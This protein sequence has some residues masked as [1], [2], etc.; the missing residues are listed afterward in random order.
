MRKARHRRPSKAAAIAGST[1][2]G[3][4]AT[5]VILSSAP[6]GA[7]VAGN[8]T[9]GGRDDL[10]AAK[11]FRVAPRAV[12]AAKTAAVTVRP[13]DSLSR[14]AMTR[15][16]NPRDWTGIY[17]RNRKVVGSNPDMVFPGERLVLDCREAAPP[18]PPADDREPDNDGDEW[19]SPAH[20]VSPARHSAPV[21]YA[22]NV[23]PGSYSGFQ[24]CV[25]TRESGGNSQ[26]MN[27]SGH[28]G[29]YQFSL[30]TWEAYGGSAADFG[31]ASVAEQNR[32]FANAMARGGQSNWSPYD[33][34]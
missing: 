11:A 3:V 8:V 5:G 14:I 6:A 13:G 1:V 23:N 25:I 29:L 30:P 16:G 34:C 28:Y 26:V 12:T 31:H 10:Q 4:I 19:H 32:V 17:D 21:S 24:R 33:G 7:Q 20:A 2:T 18:K 27:S 15:C 22:G 9:T